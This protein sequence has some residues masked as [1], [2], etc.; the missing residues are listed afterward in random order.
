MLK[1]RFVEL[2]IHG[3]GNHQ[4]IVPGDADNTGRLLQLLLDHADTVDDQ[5]GRLVDR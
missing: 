1:P 4:A 5:V 2:A 3:Y